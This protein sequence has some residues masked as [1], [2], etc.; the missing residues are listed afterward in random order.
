MAEY[1]GSI[2]L[3]NV[4]DG[5]RGPAGPQGPSGDQDAYRIETNQEEILKFIVQDA[6][7]EDGTKI[8]M[9][10]QELEISITANSADGS[11]AIIDGL[12]LEKL[13]F[14]VY[15]FDKNSWENFYFVSELINNQKGIKIKLNDTLEVDEAGGEK[16]Y[17]LKNKDE[18]I[19]KIKY[20]FESYLLTKFINVRYG[21][22]KDQAT[23]GIHANGITAS[24]QG[25]KLA[26]DA[27]GL[28]IKNA[29]LK[30][31]NKQGEDTLSFN[32]ESGDLIIK[33][34][35]HASSGVFNGKVH[36]TDGSFTGE[37]HAT[38]G[39]FDSG[40]IGSFTLKKGV[41]EANDGSISLYGGSVNERG[42]VQEAGKIVANNIELGDGAKIQNQ[43]QLGSNVFLS[44]PDSQVDKSY[45]KVFGVVD[46]NEEDE[47]PG[48][49]VNL[50]NFTANGQISLGDGQNKIVLD[51]A[52]GT[53]Y[54]DNR[55]S[56][57]GWFIS[58]QEC[59]F[60]N[61][62]VR[63]SIRASVLE[64][65]EVQAVGGILL[66][67]PSSK[68]IEATYVD[69]GEKRLL[70]LTLEDFSGFAV[71]DRCLVTSDQIGEISK[72]WGTVRELEGGEVVSDE[73][74]ISSDEEETD[75]SEEGTVSS[76]EET[77]SNETQSQDKTLKSL[78][79]KKW[80]KIELDPTFTIVDGQKVEEKEREAGFFIGKPIV[81]FGY[82]SGGQGVN[83]VGIGINGS[84]NG[85]MLTPQS[86]SVFELDSKDN[87]E[88]RIVLGKLPNKPKYGS[89]AGT[90]GLYAENALLKGALIT[91]TQG[92]NPV[93]C[94]I[95][96]QY[97]AEY[98]VSDVLRGKGFD[99]FVPSEILI[100]AGAEGD[101]IEAIQNA[102]F[103]VD[104]QGNF[105]SR[106]GYFQGSIIT[107]SIIQAAE[108]K[109]ATLT[110]KK[111]ES[112]TY[113]NQES[114]A[115]T[116]RDAAEGIVF[117]KTIDDKT[118][119]T[120][121]IF[122]L[123][124]EGLG[125]RTKFQMLDKDLGYCFQIDESGRQVAS[126]S[127][128]NDATGTLQLTGTSIGYY[129]DFKKDTKEGA[130]KS[131]IHFEEDVIK[132]SYDSAQPESEGV[133]FVIKW[134]QNEM[135]NNLFLSSSSSVK[136][137]EKMSCQPVIEGSKTVGYDL[138][139]FD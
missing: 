23:L 123:T 60:N 104:R 91:Q 112:A 68:I 120:E 18:T 135:Y 1:L 6:E 76:E 4:Q 99:N 136:Y 14:E 131:S 102:P 88:P 11:T 110:G 9:S 32:E 85:S 22:T 121:Q 62:T 59:E 81:S 45:L 34:E 8:S 80:V 49:K 66:V 107:D 97:A 118:G 103:F 55:N 47:V 17:S 43:I 35:I 40:T 129:E 95:S 64:Y 38:S 10:P 100:W 96:T 124:D 56:S 84:T 93:Y 116:I 48:I 111:P 133:K 75:S 41:L 70:K 29:G 28:T 7:S 101:S 3:V 65:G 12:T 128:V 126:G 137:G 122:K 37:I 50:V 61:V 134:E 39:T 78:T 15:D 117:L 94:G 132:F 83:N 52:T 73:E 5:D 139:I 21:I 13:S 42:E 90:Y 33:G 119:Q 16:S 53:M 30:I 63:G 115:L 72:I 138:Y 46:D 109:T 31:Q 44:N 106:N 130:L 87:L 54:S 82:V 20:E 108:I 26:F 89:I 79:R 69:E 67:R 27:S 86:L 74:E 58:N 2:T 71:N 127:F 24:I 113:N 92:S 57:T 19:L 36:A 125:L 51:G 105:Y 77:G 114:F 98:P 25:S